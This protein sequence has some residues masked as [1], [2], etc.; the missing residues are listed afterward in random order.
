MRATRETMALSIA[1]GAILLLGW[2]G[3]A[4]EAGAL[5]H[6]QSLVPT[7]TRPAPPPLPAP[8]SSPQ[9][10]SPKPRSPTLPA[11]SPTPSPVL[12]ATPG[13]PEAGGGTGAVIGWPGVLVGGGA[14][15]AVG[16]A[17]RRTGAGKQEP[18]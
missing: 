2:E 1:L 8:T 6:E 15:L 10:S 5:G 17:L 9:P 16:L 12:P 14:A 11:P 3:G 7:S 18:G 4:S 13:L